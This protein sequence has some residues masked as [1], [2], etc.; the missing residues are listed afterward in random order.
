MFFKIHIASNFKVAQ[1]ASSVTKKPTDE[2]CLGRRA[3]KGRGRKEVNALPHPAQRDPPSSWPHSTLPPCGRRPLDDFGPSMVQGFWTKYGPGSDSA[4]SYRPQPDA[5]DRYMEV[6]SAASYDQYMDFYEGYADHG[7]YGLDYGEAHPWRWR[8]SSMGIPS[9]A[10]TWCLR[11]PRETMPWHVRY[12]PRLRLG[13]AARE[14]TD[15][16]ERYKEG[17]T[18]LGDTQP[19]R[20]YSPGTRA[21]V[22]KPHR[23]KGEASPVPTPKTGKATGVPP[24]V[25]ARRSP[26]PK[27][28]RGDPPQMVTYTHILNESSS[29]IDDLIMDNWGL[30][31]QG[32]VRDEDQIKSSSEQ[33]LFT[34]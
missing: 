3:R 26:P 18:S 2:R 13:G 17:Q 15:F 8:R 12:R 7:E 33:L 5:D 27:S 21:P 10:M 19:I 30:L 23:G 34:I 28:A 29:A 31:E 16:P 32:Q 24:V 25:G 1:C 4:E 6:D 20:V 9:T 14:R 22:P 11:T